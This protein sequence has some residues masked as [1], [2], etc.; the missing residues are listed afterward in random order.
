MTGNGRNPIPEVTVMMVPAPASDQV[1]GERVDDADGAEQVGVDRLLLGAE[2]RGIAEVLGDRG[3][4]HGHDGVEA[5]GGV[6]RIV[7]CA[8]SML[9]WSV[10]SALGI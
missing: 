6:S 4:G 8:R 1:G 10:T 2:G 7:S 9:A 5:R 3:R